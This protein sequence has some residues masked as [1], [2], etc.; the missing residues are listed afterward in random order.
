MRLMVDLFEFAGDC[1]IVGVVVEQALKAKTAR[2]MVREV[3]MPIKAIKRRFSDNG[4]LCFSR[5]NFTFQVITVKLN[6]AEYSMYWHDTASYAGVLY[7]Y[8]LYI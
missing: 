7:S 6:G 3:T 5:I 8:K 4:L 2:I 1:F